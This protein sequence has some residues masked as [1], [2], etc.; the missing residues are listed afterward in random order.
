MIYQ[1]KRKLAADRISKN[2]KLLTLRYPGAALE[3][4]VYTY[5]PILGDTW[6][7][8][9]PESVII[10]LLSLEDV[11]TSWQYGR[12]NGELYQ[13]VPNGDW[14]LSGKWIFDGD[15]YLD[16]RT[17][18][19]LKCTLVMHTNPGVVPLDYAVYGLELSYTDKDYDGER[20]KIGDRKFM[21]SALSDSGIEIP[22]PNVG[23]TLFV[24]TSSGTA[25]TIVTVEPFMPGDVVIY[26][27]I[28]ARG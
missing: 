24:G 15:E 12:Y 14:V 25:L 16:G 27:M 2:G 7:L 8:T 21:V 3:Y 18:A 10:A 6:T 13:N 4:W 11:G 20:I 1:A 17:Y 28:Q 26:Y 22:K 19:W 5:D 23:G 9:V